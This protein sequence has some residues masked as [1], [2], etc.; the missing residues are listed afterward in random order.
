MKEYIV[1][2]RGAGDLATGVAYRLH[3]CGFR[4]I[5]LET[6][7]PTVIRRS[8]AFASAV[9]DGSIEVEGVRAVLAENIRHI[10][11]AWER[12]DV[13]VIV[14]ESCDILGSI[15]AHVLI[16][17]TI[18]KRNIGTRRTMADITIGLGPGFT[19]GDDVDAVVETLR[20]HELGRAKYSGSA[21]AD[22]GIPGEIA[23]FSSE[24]IVRSPADGIARSV[25][26]IG[27]IVPKGQVVA[28]VG[29]DEV[30]APIDG[31]L[32][33]IIHDGIF[34]KKGM[35]MGDVDP[36]GNVNN[37][38]TISEKAL[39]VAGGVLEAVLHIGFKNGRLSLKDK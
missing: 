13:P 20:G 9:F 10:E 31:V 33:G 1:A 15:R 38:F 35:K 28:Y 12:G 11:E 39:A 29:E 18:S 14:D 37:C 4:L 5:M 25:C 2:I 36:R 17:A 24:R 23:G 8:V 7:R 27:D 19:A 26:S 32:R 21:A 6:A 30:L 3:M 16:D 22:T 34:V